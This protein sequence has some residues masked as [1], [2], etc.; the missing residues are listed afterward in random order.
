MVVKNDP[1]Q[2]SYTGL[3]CNCYKNKSPQ[4]PDHDSVFKYQK[5]ISQMHHIIA[6]TQA[7]TGKPPCLQ[8][9]AFTTL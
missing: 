9:S 7:A 4:H 6:V 2:H 3:W 8:P 5:V 1:V